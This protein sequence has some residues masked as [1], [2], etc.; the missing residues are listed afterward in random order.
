MISKTTR[1]ENNKFY[2]DFD[3]KT[4]DLKNKRK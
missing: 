3:V 4:K 1:V 2:L